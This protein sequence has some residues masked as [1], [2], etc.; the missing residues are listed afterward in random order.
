MT[1]ILK[2]VVFTVVCFAA[3]GGFWF[4]VIQAPGQA[5]E[6]ADVTVEG[7]V[8]TAEIDVSTVQS[9]DGAGTDRTY[10]PE[11]TYRYTYGGETYTNDNLW[12]GPGDGSSYGQRSEAEAITSQ[13]PAGSSVSIHL[14]SDNPSQ[15]FLKTKPT[16]LNDYFPVALL[17]LFGV[18]GLGSLA[19]QA[20]GDDE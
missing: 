20:L 6:R 18:L 3:A 14:N 17:L 16:S 4:L 13:Y 5:A 7:T 19:Q 1:K 11:V 2:T 12:A 8:V 9:D 15:S 10:S